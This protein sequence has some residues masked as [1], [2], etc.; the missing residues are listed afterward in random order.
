[1][2]KNDYFQSNSIKKTKDWWNREKQI[3][4]RRNKC[5][6]KKKK[7]TKKNQH[8]WKITSFL[9]VFIVKLSFLVKEFVES[10]ESSSFSFSLSSLSFFNNVY[11]LKFTHDK[12]DE[13]E[14]SNVGFLLIFFGFWSLVNFFSDFS[15]RV[16][17][18]ENQK[19]QKHTPK[20]VTLALLWQIII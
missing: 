9:V 11:A 17:E 10:P 14:R 1:M 20:S 6:Y 4:Q 5:G 8:W 3:N 7:T 19:I 13:R 16:C 18:R 2:G 15:L 12:E